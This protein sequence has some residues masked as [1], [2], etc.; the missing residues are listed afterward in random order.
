MLSLQHKLVTQ[1]IL[2]IQE[3]EIQQKN[4][5]KVL[6]DS[7]CLRIISNINFSNKTSCVSAAVQAPYSLKNVR[8]QA[9]HAA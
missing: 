2:I 9:V 7:Q 6:A 3:H 8:S 5:C 4:K 1:V